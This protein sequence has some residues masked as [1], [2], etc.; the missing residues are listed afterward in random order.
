MGA[1]QEALYREEVYTSLKPLLITSLIIDVFDFFFSYFFHGIATNTLIKLKILI[2]IGFKFYI[3]WNSTSI[4]KLTLICECLNPM[5]MQVCI[6]S[7]LLF[8][9]FYLSYFSL[10]SKKFNKNFSHK[11]LNS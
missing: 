1:N 6:L 10:T 11:Y 4:Y 3:K 5:T 8:F 7:S 2:S 9:S